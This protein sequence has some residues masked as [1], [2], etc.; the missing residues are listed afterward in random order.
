MYKRVLKWESSLF[1][2]NEPVPDLMSNF[3]LLSQRMITW[4]SLWNE[5]T[6]I[7]ILIVDQLM[8]LFF[9]L[10]IIVIVILETLRFSRLNESN[11][12]LVTICAVI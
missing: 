7:D 11:A 10:S 12:G 1:A 9:G 8:R 4:T 3:T 5:T 6:A 2:Y